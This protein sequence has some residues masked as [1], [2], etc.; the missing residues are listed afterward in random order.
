LNELSTEVTETEKAHIPTQNEKLP[1]PAATGRDNKTVTTVGFFSLS[2]NGSGFLGKPNK[3]GQFSKN[4][5]VLLSSQIDFV[6][7]TKTAFA[8]PPA[9]VHHQFTTT[10]TSSA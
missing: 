2:R 5:L 1:L 10:L 3:T 9:A 7:N 6:E 4:R 8:I